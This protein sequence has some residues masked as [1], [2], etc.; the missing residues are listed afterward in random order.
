[1]TSTP[2][3]RKIRAVNRRFREARMIAKALKSPNHPILA[4]IIP[5]RRCNLSCG[6]CNE[7]DNFSKPVPTPEMLR[8]IDLLAGLGTTA[9]TLSGGEPLLHPELDEII[10]RIR[11]NGMMAEL[12]TNGYLLTPQRIAR[13]NRAG[14]DHLQI[15]IDNVLPDE[16][17]KKSLKVLDRKLEW[18]AKIASFD[19][20]INTVVGGGIRNA[21]DAVVIARRARALGLST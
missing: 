13:L 4:H 8:R 18:L 10:R 6:Y 1:M 16:I 7:Y 15:S 9:V 20:V 2:L 12:I 5:V 17:S 14:L 11:S 21:D 3:K 19:V